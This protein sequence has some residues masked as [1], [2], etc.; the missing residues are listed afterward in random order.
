MKD[1]NQRYRTPAEV[2]V[3]LERW[4]PA[5][6]PV[7]KI[8]EMPKLSPAAETALNDL[9]KA[10]NSISAAQLK[11]ETELAETAPFASPAAIDHG[12]MMKGDTAR[13]GTATKAAP[14]K[15]STKPAY[16]NP[17]QPTEPHTSMET[18]SPV[19]ATKSSTQ[20]PVYQ[21]KPVVHAAVPGSLPKAGPGMNVPNLTSGVPGAFPFI[22]MPLPDHTSAN[23]MRL[24]IGLVTVAL[25]L[26]VGL[27]LYK[28]GLGKPKPLAAPVDNKSLTTD[29]GK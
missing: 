16:G 9:P 3:E 5:E 11:K 2:A 4:A 1:P 19:T 12:A 21:P 14:T 29:E 22:A 25:V 17:F 13:S 8:E 24:V 26:S 27:F 10:G 15:S 18:P 7:P 20:V 23:R 6:V 28:F